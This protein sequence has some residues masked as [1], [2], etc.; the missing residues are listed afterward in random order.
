M[1]GQTGTIQSPG[2]PGNYPNYTRCIWILQAPDKYTTQLTV[3]FVGE[4]Y[5]SQCSDYV[6]VCVCWVVQVGWW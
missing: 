1:A 2:Y 6:E 3:N 5:N 4:T